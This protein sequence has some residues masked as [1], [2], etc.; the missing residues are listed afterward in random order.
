[1]E[2]IYISELGKPELNEDTLAHYGVLGMKWGVRKNP[3]KAYAKAMAK[4]DRLRKKASG[5]YAR[6]LLSASKKSRKANIKSAKA[7]KKYL[8]AINNPF[9]SKSK[10]TDLSLN[11]DKAQA[12]AA[13][14]QAKTDKAL[15]STAKFAKKEI[16]WNRAV[17]KAFKDFDTNQLKKQYTDQKKEKRSDLTKLSY[18]DY[19]KKYSNKNSGSKNWNDMSE[20]EKQKQLK[21]DLAEE[22]K[23]FAKREAELAK[24]YPPGSNPYYQ[25]KAYLKS[26]K[27]K[28]K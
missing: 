13:Q 5:K 1:M 9:T 24:K 14:V 23:Y 25:S 4:T 11:K 15:S 27:K 26:Q 2:K 17:D 7:S 12:K 21:K 3:A 28:K 20:A 6:R 22:S 19:I 10:L 8:K 16:K 18:D